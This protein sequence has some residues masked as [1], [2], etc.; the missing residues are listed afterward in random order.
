VSEIISHDEAQGYLSKYQGDV[1]ASHKD[2][3][4]IMTHLRE[5]HKDGRLTG[6][7]F[8]LRAEQAVKSESQVALAMTIRDLPKPPPHVGLA[9][10]VCKDLEEA[11]R[12]HRNAFH[13]LLTIVF[14]TGMAASIAI[15][16]ILVHH[17]WNPGSAWDIFPIFGGLIF[18]ASLFVN[19]LTWAFD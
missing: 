4:K 6:E 16:N 17:L 10:K 12:D 13:A 15:P 18:G 5:A 11:H 2:R 14:A 3:N 8:N 19:F 7:Q 9:T 1:R